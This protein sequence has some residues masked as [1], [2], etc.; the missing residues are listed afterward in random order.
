MSHRSLTA[1]FTAI[2]VVALMPLFATA[3]STNTPAPARTPWGDPDL[4]GV[5]NNGTITPMQRPEEL[6]DKE[7][8]TEE[9]AANLEQETVDREERL[10]NRPARRTEAGASVDTGEDGATGAYNDFWLDRGTTT[11]GT[12]RTSLIVDPPNGRIPPVTPEA[13][14]RAETRRAYRR[15]HPA[16]SWEDRGLNDRCMFTTGLPIVPSAYNNNVQFFQTPDHVAM[17]IEMTHTLRVILLDG[18]SPS[19]LSQFVGVSRGHWEGDTL[20]VETTNFHRLTSL[21]GSTSNARL[22]ERFTRV[23]PETIEYE[24]TVED[25]D[26]WPQPWTVQVELTKTDEPLYEYACHEGNYSMEGILAGARAQEN[27]T[28]EAGKLREP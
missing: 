23:G 10:L 7:F 25:P 5:W 27:A 17:L 24:F 12:R 22:L 20:V 2:A 13:E 4:Q 19:N 6:A 21:R 11:I 18:R 26:T 8:L 14:K 9:E 15:E 16:D 28:A 1:V 3:Q